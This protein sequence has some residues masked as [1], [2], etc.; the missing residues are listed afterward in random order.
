MFLRVGPH[1]DA[2]DDRVSVGYFVE[3]P[4]L[5]E[6]VQLANQIE[7]Q[8]GK[9]LAVQT[10]L[11][12]PAQTKALVGQAVEQFGRID[13]LV[14]NAGYGEGGPIE[15]LGRAEMRR[16]FE[17]NLFAALE[18]CGLAAPIM[19]RQG[20]G[21]IINVSSLSARPCSAQWRRTVFSLTP[22]SAPISPLFRPTKKR[23]LTTRAL[24]SSSDSRRSIRLN[25]VKVR[26]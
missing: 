8:G 18:L 25:P 26:S 9:A 5:L 7:A 16:Q 6:V 13:V 24:I 14:N 21:R 12:D 19:R 1:P 20:R 22:I 10:D 15:L 17:V 11:S 3:I 2:H 23:N 4:P